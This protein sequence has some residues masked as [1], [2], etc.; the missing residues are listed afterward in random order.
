MIEHQNMEHSTLQKQRMNEQSIEKTQQLQSHL[1]DHKNM[2][3]TGGQPLE[4][5]TEEHVPVLITQQ[6]EE[7][8]QLVQKAHTRFS[9]ARAKKA[10]SGSPTQNQ[11]P[12]RKTFKQKREDKR[13]DL[14]AKEITPVADHVS[15]HMMESL[16]ANKQLQDNAMDLI[17]NN[18]EVH[19]KESVDW[20]VMRTFM[21]GFAT[22]K[23]GEPVGKKNRLRKQ[24]NI[25]FIND[26]CSGDVELRRPHLDRM[27]EEALSVNITE[28]ML[29]AEYLEYHAGEVKLQVSKL[30]Y[31]HNVYKDPINQ[32]YFDELSQ[33]TKNL[34]EYRILSRY[35]PLGLVMAHVCAQ[36]AVDADHLQ[37]KK[38]VRD[39]SE[40]E[41]FTTMLEGER[42]LLHSELERTNRLEREL[43]EKTGDEE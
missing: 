39:K 38:H 40:L 10:A 19:V 9:F 26:Y 32:P 34:I 6:V 14:V 13:L 42:Q 21:K 7:N 8:E 16:M 30:V 22:D 28:D 36:N 27:L 12:A 23:N 29:T 31:F 35:A 18:P 5:Q 11:K 25:R 24:E 4:M 1:T 20:R 41:V 37:I 17:K 43:R 2:E 15:I 33:A 3:M